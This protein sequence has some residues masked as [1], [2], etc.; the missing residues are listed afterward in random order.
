MKNK[1]ALG[2]FLF[3]LPLPLFKTKGEGGKPLGLAEVQLRVA[4]FFA[5]RGRDKDGGETDET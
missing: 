1:R 2:Q 3:I 5:L 4:E